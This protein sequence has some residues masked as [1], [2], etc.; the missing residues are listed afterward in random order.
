MMHIDFP[1]QFD[2]LGRTGQCNKNKHIRDMIELVLFTSPGERLNRPDFGCGL[3]QLVFAP[4]N[5]ITASTIQLTIQ[6]SLNKWLGSLIDINNVSIQKEEE[7]LIIVVDYTVKK[8][9][10]G[11][12]AIFTR[13]V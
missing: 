6:S 8:S 1:Y 11:N 4:N 9:K 10:Q 7:K 2:Q 12:T 5:D 13:A 3:L